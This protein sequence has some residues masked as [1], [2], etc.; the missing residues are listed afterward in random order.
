MRR[1]SRIDESFQRHRLS[2]IEFICFATVITVLSLSLPAAAE[3]VKNP[4][5][6]VI[7][8]SVAFIFDDGLNRA[9]EST[10]APIGT[11]FMIGLESKK[12]PGQFYK[13]M[14]T[15]EHV[16]RGRSKIKFRFNNSTEPGFVFHDIDLRKQNIFRA[17]DFVDLVAV[18]VPD[19]PKTNPTLFDY[20]M[21]LD[22]QK[23]TSFEVDEGTEIVSIGYLFPY[24]GLKQNY[25]VFRFGRLAI[26]SDERWSCSERGPVEQAYIAEIHALGGS[27]G[28]PVI[29]Q[30]SQ[31]KLNSNGVMQFRR[32][33]PLIVGVL[34]GHPSAPAPIA[35]RIA[36][37]EYIKTPDKFAL[38]SPGLALLE[39][40]ENLR[41]LMLSIASYIRANGGDVVLNQ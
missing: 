10:E 34:K 37:G 20:S 25:P 9:A 18:S 22:K 29:L 23:M 27:S 39:P 8:D 13:F 24:A 6:K 7:R 17:P 33:P 31:I 41:Q 36:T 2:S 14:V 40:S 30:P 3:E 15:N 35:D 38:V 28:S 11:S 12:F 1:V 32:I 21:I 5:L 4:D 19:I 26:L 16:L